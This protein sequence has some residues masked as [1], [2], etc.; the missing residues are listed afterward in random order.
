MVGHLQWLWHRVVRKATGRSIPSEVLARRYVYAG[1]V[2]WTTGYTEFKH[3]AIRDAL[4]DT[5]LLR[6]FAEHGP[7]PDRYA[8]GL[9]ER[10]VECPWVFAQLRGCG[11]RL[12]DAG[13]ALNHPEMLDHPALADRTVTACTLAPEAQR[14]R[15]HVSYVYADLRDVPF[16]DGWFDVVVCLSTLEHIGLDNTRQYTADRR[17]AEN[18]RDGWR[19]AVREMRRVLRPGGVLLLTVP[20]GRPEHFGWAQVFDRAGLDAVVREFGGRAVDQ[21]FFLYGRDGWST[22]TAEECADARYHDYTRG[23]PPPPDGAAAARAIACVRLE[24]S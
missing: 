6:Q 20:F 24:A 4:A 22:A 11:P 23:G 16:R 21:D 15:P 3:R 7:L 17:F 19:P 12:L 5:V 8:V 10:L 9:D 2:A 1:R 18:D 13:S 14:G